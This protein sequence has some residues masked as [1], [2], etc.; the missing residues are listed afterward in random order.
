MV[1]LGKDSFDVKI[2]VFDEDTT[3]EFLKES[4][5]DIKN[6]PFKGNHKSK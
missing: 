3:F 6:L 5:Y 2:G 1:V 4:G